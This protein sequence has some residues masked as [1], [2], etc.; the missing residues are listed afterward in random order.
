MY[1]QSCTRA[2][3]SRGRSTIGIHLTSP[4]DYSRFNNNQKSSRTATKQLEVLQ[5]KRMSSTRIWQRRSCGDKCGSV[6]RSEVIRPEHRGGGVNRDELLLSSSSPTWEIPP[7]RG[8]DASRR[9]KGVLFIPFLWAAVELCCFAVFLIIPIAVAGVANARRRTPGSSP[10]D[11]D[12][13]P[14]SLALW[15]LFT[16][17]AGGNSYTRR[18]Q[19]LKADARKRVCVTC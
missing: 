8:V 16:I 10:Q 17:N 9:P 7:L 13:D 1:I 19:L 3:T 15:F 12:S 6:L 18:D 5:V 2:K 14:C 4:M 11:G